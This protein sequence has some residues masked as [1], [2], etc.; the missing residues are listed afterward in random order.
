MKSLPIFLPL[1]L[2][3]PLQAAI[4]PL[5][6]PL[7]DNLASEAGNTGN[8]YAYPAIQGLPDATKAAGGVR[9]RYNDGAV[10][11]E[12]SSLGQ[13]FA[14]FDP[15]GTY[16]AGIV[17][18]VRS[19]LYPPPTAT[20]AQVNKTLVEGGAAFRYLSLLYS[21]DG[22][23]GD[24]TNHYQDMSQWYGE[25][26]RIAIA[27]QITRLE[28]ALAV[29]PLDYQLRGLLLDAYTDRAV[30]EMQF[31]KQDL[32]ALGRLRLGLVL[33]SA[34]VID[35]EIA[36]L[37]TIS[38]KYLSVLTQF[39]GLLSNPV[40]GVEPTD[41]DPSVPRGT[42]F[43]YYIFQK[44]QP[45]RNQV[46]SRYFEST[47]PDAVPT[48][49][50]VFNEPAKVA[51]QPLG[52]G[53]VAQ[54]NAPG[55]LKVSVTN[56]TSVSLT[57]VDNSTNETGF[58]VEFRPFS[59]AAWPPGPGTTLAANV[60]T[61]PITGLTTGQTYMFRV[62][63]KLGATINSP[64]S[65]LVSATPSPASTVPRPVNEILANGY[66]D[67]VTLLTV[68]SEFVT[69]SAELNRMRGLRQLPR[70]GN[71]AGDLETARNDISSL[72][73][74]MPTNLALLRAMF[75]EDQAAFQPGNTSGIFGA[76]AGVETAIG[77]LT[78]TRAFLNGTA[79]LLGLDPNFLILLQTDSEASYVNDAS[80][81]VRGF[82]SFA[83]IVSRLR[84]AN[85]PL[86]VALAK[87]V[88]ARAKFNTFR[89]SVDQVVAE[90]YDESVA[91]GDRFREIT[92][93]DVDYLTESY[94]IVDPAWNGKDFN[95]TRSSEL[96]Q[97]KVEQ[98]LLRD[99]LTKIREQLALFDA[100][101]AQS[102]TTLTKARGLDNAR[103]T[104]ETDFLS[105]TEWLYGGMAIANGA[106]AA[107]QAG[108]EGVYAG[109]SASTPF[110]LGAVGVAAAA[111]ITAQAANAT[112][113]VFLGQAIDKAGRAFEK[114][115]AG[116]ENALTVS[117]A[118]E[119]ILGLQR[120]KNAAII[121]LQEVQSA[122]AQLAG[123][124]AALRAELVRI[125]AIFK[126]SD[127][128][129]RSTLHANPIHYL[130][131]QTAIIDADAAFAEAQRWMFYAQRALEHKWTQ[132]F[133]VTSGGKNYDS[134]SLFKMRNADELEDLLTAYFNFDANRE[135]GQSPKL[136]TSVISFKDHILA[137]KPNLF[138]AANPPENGYR[139]DPATGQS[140]TQT[141][142]FRK[143]LQ[144]SRDIAGNIVIPFNTA[145]LQDIQGLFSGPTYGP[146][147]AVI[148]TGQWRDKI[149][150]VKVN[151]VAQDGPVPGPGGVQPRIINGSLTYGGQNY[152]R[153]RV[154]PGGT[155]ALYVSRP[156]NAEPEDQTG[157]FTVNTFRN[158]TSPKLD[159]V[160]V[161][162]DSL[163]GTG[164]FAYSALTAR[165]S[166][167]DLTQEDNLG[168]T[169][170]FNDFRELSVA[171]T[172][173]VLT[174]FAAQPNQII[175][176][177]R[178]QDIEL[179]IRHRSFSRIS[180]SF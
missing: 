23:S 61:T 156:S 176:L 58:L 35:E 94:P 100:G 76:R 101:E 159:N 118:Q 26:E 44:D 3:L 134:G 148:G 27:Q 122:L 115:V 151:I 127:E 91:F 110:G 116:A 130:R 22:N 144:A 71:V 75:S 117:Q 162:Q 102:N 20:R 12:E 121:Q 40:D 88:D 2:S 155:P 21:E 147:G 85:R 114:T 173:W 179:I 166:S 10:T 161:T 84:G 37:K 14:P 24:V 169:F 178:I 8:L 99:T 126:A 4:G 6:R 67:Y 125:E 78:N 15:G 1:L 49:L 149:I 143:K 87:Q 25:P 9:G 104:A 160:F 54:G 48:D 68:M 55:S 28:E 95:P 174:I 57:W 105:T 32:E 112:A 52:T 93:Y 175:N 51:G 63:A 145:I 30:A 59:A 34:F 146:T 42:P 92:G 154:V 120:D 98:D 17:A 39:S 5:A 16:V 103:T 119:A 70:S 167:A 136:T 46:R 66:R 13:P 133:T 140:I 108:A 29:A 74:T 7:F 135:L 65:N 56:A 82:D 165:A 45:N 171:S 124:D 64:F 137:P 131:S 41:F 80:Q 168:P 89:E 62:S 163:N 86:T 83:Q 113:N 123:R 19:K 177:D 180:P 142:L 141:T 36:L 170:Q 139:S 60:T 77:T 172:G 138:D 129:I 128:Y 90:R 53:T 33:A 31:V 38:D 79:N 50:P 43:G 73:S 96:K 18:E 132:R 111:N 152:F 153:T 69:R 106:A 109:A 157:E 47:A 72:L 81:T 97:V 150:Y 158:Y 11:L 164:S 107:A